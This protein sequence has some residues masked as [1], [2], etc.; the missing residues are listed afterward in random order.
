[1]PPRPGFR[2]IKIQ[3]GVDVAGFLRD[4]SR[5]AF[6]RGL[7]D[8]IF[9]AGRRAYTEMRQR[10]ATAA[11][12]PGLD[13]HRAPFF[14]QEAMLCPACA[15]P[16]YMSADGVLIC[17]KCER[18]FGFVPGAALG[19]HPTSRQAP[20]S[21][22][23]PDGHPWFDQ[24]PPRGRR[25][26]GRN[27]THKVPRGPHVPPP[28]SYTPPPEPEPED[29][30]RAD[31]RLIGVQP[32]DVSEELVKRRRRELAM[33]HHSDLGGDESKMAEINAAADRLINAARQGISI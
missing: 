1:M 8:E 26:P 20:P 11:A 12:A 5:S 13:P 32:S 2:S 6:G 23:D 28:R 21:S 15:L 19:G 16:I 30:L 31:C 29:Q 17:L 9:N 25:A 14:Q 24:R 18:Q 33:T 4:A 10:Q 22:F 7:G 27:N 3:V